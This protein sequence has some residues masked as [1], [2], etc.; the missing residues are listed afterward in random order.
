M[1]FFVLASCTKGVDTPEGLLV[2]F[3]KDVTTKNMD[4]DYYLKF[5]TGKL[6]KKIEELS[7]EEFEEY[8]DL[9]KVANPK[10]DVLKKN[11]SGDDKCSL[12]YI[13]KFDYAAKTDGAFKTEV[14]KVANLELVEKEWKIEDVTNMKTYHEAK[15]PINALQDI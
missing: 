1:C 9:R 12:T 4:K 15:T 14:K 3:T 5:T 13:V 8:R 6:N 7:D 2:K 10:I 11:C